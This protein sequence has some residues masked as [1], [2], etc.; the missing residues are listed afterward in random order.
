MRLHVCIL[1]YTYILEYNPVLLFC[2]KTTWKNK[3]STNDRIAVLFYFSH[4]TISHCCIF[5][6]DVFILTA[7]DLGPLKKL[8]IRHDNSRSPSSWYL[9][10]VEIVDTKDDTT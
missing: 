10:R 6:E 8:R 4:D 5:Q 7:I 2:P 1:S 9:D 3:M